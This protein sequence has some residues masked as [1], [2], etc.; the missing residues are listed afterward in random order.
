MSETSFGFFI[1][2]VIWVGILGSCTIGSCKY[3][4]AED[5]CTDTRLVV[6]FKTSSGGKEKIDEMEK[7]VSTAPCR[8]NEWTTIST[9]TT[10]ATLKVEFVKRK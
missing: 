10:D 8:S 7:W 1:A 4:Q 9:K 3:H 6:E 2:T 5:E